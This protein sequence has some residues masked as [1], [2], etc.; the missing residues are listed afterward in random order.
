MEGDCESARM[1]FRKELSE[2]VTLSQSFAY[3]E[4]VS[5]VPLSWGDSVVGE[6]NASAKVLRQ[7]LLGV[8]IGHQFRGGS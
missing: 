6:G 4:V 7:K 1:L 3:S 2:E 8:H 5:C